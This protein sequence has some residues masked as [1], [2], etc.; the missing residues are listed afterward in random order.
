MAHLKQ[1][2]K[3]RA[4]RKGHVSAD[5][6]DFHQRTLQLNGTVFVQDESGFQNLE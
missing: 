4:K 1:P 3:K 2:Q 5:G 6:K